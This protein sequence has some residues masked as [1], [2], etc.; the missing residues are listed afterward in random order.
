MTAK[1][2][3]KQTGHDI[4]WAPWRIEYIADA[5]KNAGCVFCDAVKGSQDR[6][7]LIVHR[8]K[9]TFV[10]MNK[11]PYNNGHLMVVPYQ[12]THEMTSLDE[13]EK[14]ELFNLL[15]VSQEVLAEVMKPQGFNIG[16]N[17]GRLAGAGILEHLHFHIVPRWGGDTNFMPVIGHTKVISE[18]LEKTWE[19]LAHAFDR[20]F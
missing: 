8:G 15:Q 10:I 17:L 9:K 19:K 13:Q 2:T 6:K 12:H 4:L 5:S 16:M 7:N 20:R 14:V 1:D 11:Y 3:E 18:A